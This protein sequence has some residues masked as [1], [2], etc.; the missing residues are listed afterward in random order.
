MASLDRESVNISV[1]PPQSSFSGRLNME[2]FRFK[3][4]QQS[5][6]AGQTPPRR[7]TRLSL[8][9][10]KIESP[11]RASPA[12]M[13]NN[14]KRKATVLASEDAGVPALP[15]GSTEAEADAADD[16]SPSS[17]PTP[18]GT[19]KPKKR[20]RQK[21]GYQPPSVYAHLPPLPDALAPNMHALFCGLNPGVRTA[22][23]GHAYNHPSNLFWKLMFS[24]GVLPVRC[25]AE[26]DRTLP[27][28]FRLGLTNIVSRPSRNGAELSKAEMDAGV[29]ALE[30]KVRVWRPLAVVMVGK[31][32]WES[33][34]R[35]RHGRGIA[36]HEFKYGW[37]DESENMGAGDVGD[38]ERQEGVE[39][40]DGWKGARVFVASSTSGLAATLS[41]A[42]KER[43]WRELGRWVEARRAGRDVPPGLVDD[44]S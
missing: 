3:A 26:E 17:T 1:S 21:S 6:P 9:P 20:N 15:D 34:W 41:P 42:E 30:A 38:S 10:R 8:T 5:P 22:Q 24:S 18:S 29:G 32:I 44:M 40:R 36:K 4:E 2:N 33:V 12:S 7:S 43:I 25:V 19:K 39:Y 28:R 13:G 27:E 16:S 23:T 37:Q 11:T 14:R 35:V 31:S